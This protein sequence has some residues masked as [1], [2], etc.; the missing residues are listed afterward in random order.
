M[1][2]GKIYVWDLVVRLFHWSLV[3]LFI[4]AYSTGEGKGLL[5]R[6][7]GYA[8]LLL[9]LFRVIWGFIGSEYARFANFVCPPRM[10]LGYL[11]DLVAGK[12]Q[13]YIG[14]NPAAA[15]MIL[16]LL[17][18]SLIVCTTGVMACNERRDS[19]GASGSFGL[20]TPAYAD[21]YNGK[22]HRRWRDHD[23]RA[24]DNE[25]KFWGEV[26]EASAEFLLIL[27]AFHVVGVAVSSRAHKENLIQSMVSGQKNTRAGSFPHHV[28]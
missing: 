22:H 24:A 16:F 21:G 17:A 20:A 23:D 13:Y 27:I 15:W 25:R 6:N 10:A 18:T 8:I 9:V 19:T 12:A 5:H 7:I 3:M 4:L 14:H 11:K 1:P 26:H 28:K 2:T